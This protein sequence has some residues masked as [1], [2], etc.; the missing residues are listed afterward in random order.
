MEVLYPIEVPQLPRFKT[1]DAGVC[2]EYIKDHSKT[3]NFDLSRT[4][5]LVKFAH[6]DCAIGRVSVNWC[7]LTSTEGFRITKAASA[8]YYSFQFVIR[9]NCQLDGVFG[10]K[11]VGPGDVFILDP[12][13]ITREFWPEDCQQFIVRID[14][15][16]VEQ[17][18]SEELAKKLSKH[19]VFDPVASDPGIT[20]WLGQ[21]SR[22]LW[23]GGS[24]AALIGHGRVAQNIER[25]L[26]TMLLSGLHHSESDDFIR[27]GQGAAPYYVKRAEAFIH[28]QARDELTVDEIADKAGVSARSLFYGF[29]RWRNK[30]PMAYVRD[31]R[32]DLARK[33]LQKARISGGTVSE[34][35]I[36]AGFTNFSQFSKIY[37]AR[38]GETPSA[39]LR[40]G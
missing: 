38:F 23:I 35:A 26:I 21:I 27:Q 4:S 6:H 39:T 14:R 15:Q 36:N 16:I 29:K 22:S 5:Q 24:E 2:R 17:L 11:A 10:S 19:V 31:V 1:S 12:D 28:D 25:M 13:H 7:D 18:L 40:V 8:P 34:A 3:H 37:K 30:T 32:L 9:G 33:E 20:R